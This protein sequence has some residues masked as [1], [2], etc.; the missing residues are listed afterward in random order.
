MQA[1]VVIW[2]AT[3]WLFLVG[4]SP[5]G[6]SGTLVVSYSGE[7]KVALLDPAS[8]EARAVLPVGAGPHEITLTRDGATAYVAISGADPQAEPGRTIAVIDVKARKLQA[9]FELTDC[10]Q[11]HDTRLSPDESVLWIAC[12]PA[13]AVLEIDARTGEHR[14]KLKTNLDGGW[15][16]EAAPDG[17]KLYVP[18]LEG[19][20]ITAIE[21][22]SG[23]ARTVY[24]GTTQFGIAIAPDGREAWVSDS[25]RHQLTMVV[26]AT[27][28]VAG[29]V[30]LGAPPQ[31]QP[32]FA[33]LRFTPDGSSVL[34]VRGAALLLIDARKRAVAWSLE[35][36]H[37][38][39]VLT[40]SPDGRF[41]AVSHPRADRVSVMDLRARVVRATFSVGK[42]PDGV[43]WA[44]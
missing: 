16:V 36:P 13:Q 42:T 22:A 24:S 21:A 40:V 33:R 38:G 28:K 14:R 15:F 12:A 23:E 4:A 34:V 29:S 20:A 3:L 41:A 9:T 19:K 43:A 6:P 1:H 31:G 2:I 8:G 32:A 27:D 25:D 17:R 7:A 30:S 26:T 11:P 5:Q 44:P 39:K 10:R 35:L 37:P 18:H